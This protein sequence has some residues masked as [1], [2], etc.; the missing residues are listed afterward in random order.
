MDCLLSLLPY[1]LL[2]LGS[3]ANLGSFTRTGT[4]LLFASEGVF[5]AIAGFGRERRQRRQVVVFEA[6]R[7]T[8][9]GVTDEEQLPA[10]PLAQFTKPEMQPYLEPL[11]KR[12][13]PVQR[14]RY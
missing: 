5:N 11:S 12:G 13:W 3:R 8:T 9:Y 14:F 6:V 10:I 4:E 1:W 2:I 7:V